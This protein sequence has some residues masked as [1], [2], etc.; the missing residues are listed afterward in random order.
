[1]RPDVVAGLLFVA[2]TVVLLVGLIAWPLFQ[3]FALSFYEVNPLTLASRPVGL[4]NYTD[5]LTHEEF[6]HALRANL[7]WVAGSVA[8]QVVLGVALALMLHRSFTGRSVARALL[9][10]PYLLPTVVAVLVWQWM[11]NDLYGVVDYAISVLGFSPPDWLGAMPEAMVIV[12]VIGGWKLFPFVM[13]AVLAR[14]Q[15]IPQQLYEAA[16]IDGAGSL[17]RFWDITLPQLR[18]VLLVVVLLRA[19]WDF[20]E[21]D[22]IYLLTGGGPTDSTTTLP[23]LVYKEAFQLLHMGRASAIAVLML[24]VMMLF[25]GLYFAIAGRAAREGERA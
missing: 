19:I 7:V 3:A 1:M 8:L 6:W 16:A 13:L 23:L 15:S 10:F 21:F 18:T 17:S 11:L 25:I 5:L 12:I 20:K 24:L 14:L 22:L 2:P 9:L 4:A